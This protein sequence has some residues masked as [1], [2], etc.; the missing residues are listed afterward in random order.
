MITKPHKLLM[1]KSQKETNQ[2]L[3]SEILK[4]ENEEES[5]AFESEYKG[6]TQLNIGGRISLYDSM[7][8]L[9]YSIESYHIDYLKK[10]LVADLFKKLESF[11]ANT[12]A[13]N[14][15]VF[16]NGSSPKLKNF[17]YINYPVFHFLKNHIEKG[18]AHRD[19]AIYDKSEVVDNLETPKL[20]TLVCNVF[21]GVT[22]YLNIQKHLGTTETKT[23]RLEAGEAIIFNS[24]LK[25]DIS[26][27]ENKEG[28]SYT[29]ARASLVA[30][31]SIEE[32]DTVL[33]RI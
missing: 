8:N 1:G 3:I 33:F 20:F 28:H 24:A 26:P 30:Q 11:V 32:G 13:A 10:F 9:G 4:F 17:Y 22:F 21:G 14:F 23:V 5:L 29:E 19:L 18:G 25:H 16:S 12:M 31:F 27:F 2:A 6:V 7:M 15:A